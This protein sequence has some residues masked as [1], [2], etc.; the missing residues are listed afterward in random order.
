MTARIDS[1]KGLRLEEL[2]TDELRARL[3]TLKADVAELRQRVA[4]AEAEARS[5]KL[6][7][8]D[9]AFAKARQARDEAAGDIA[10]IEGSIAYGEEGL[11]ITI[12]VDRDRAIKARETGLKRAAGSQAKAYEEDATRLLAA[13]DA[14]AESIERLNARHAD[15]TRTRA[16]ATVL[17]YVSGR[18]VIDL[19]APASPAQDGRL[20]AAVAKV[21]A[22]SLADAKALPA[23]LTSLPWDGSGLSLHTLLSRL[24]DTPTEKLVQEAPPPEWA[25]AE[26]WQRHVDTIQQEARQAEAAQREHQAATVDAW[27]REMLAGGPIPLAGIEREAA[28]AGIKLRVPMGEGSDHASLYT[29]AERVGVA[30]IQERT[31]SVIYWSRGADYD[32]DRYVP[33]MA[34]SGLGALRG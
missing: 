14:F 23:R 30:A 12:G 26:A 6:R 1:V 31:T 17:A 25:S 11:E 33:L 10:L 9:E 20:K 32:S 15:L 4:D 3:S 19:P 16:E 8:D 28:K 18:D 34:R 13:A 27:L 24:R 29:A 21:R 7:G 22:A 2:T 5:A